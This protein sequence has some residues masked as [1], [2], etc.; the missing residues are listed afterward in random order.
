MTWLQITGFHSL[1]RRPGVPAEEL[2]GHAFSQGLTGESFLPL[3][4]S[5]EPLWFLG[6]NLPSHPE[7]HAS[8]V[9]FWGRRGVRGPSERG[10]HKESK[11]IKL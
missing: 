1:S 9:K 5:V 2:A 3:L 7:I 10:T 4:A 6:R 11:T 8:L